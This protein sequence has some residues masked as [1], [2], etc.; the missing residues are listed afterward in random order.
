MIVQSLRSSPAANPSSITESRPRAAF[1]LI[2]D[3]EKSILTLIARS[4]RQFM[5]M[6]E[7]CGDAASALAAIKHR[8]PDFIF[9]DVSLE[10]FDA[11]EVIRGL[12]E[13]QF[14]GNIQL[15]SGRDLPLLEDIKRVGE[16]YSLKML[17]VLQKPFRIDAIMEILRH[18]G[19]GRSSGPGAKVSLFS[20][21]CAG[22]LELNY[23]PIVDL[24]TMHLA[25]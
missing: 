3:D 5:V 17:P 7:E 24:R 6:T 16:R 23:Q 1:C 25:G 4:L 9:L 13:I 14:S 11:V 12:G 19:L 15:M 2:V 22:W 20:A 8:T 10:R 18:A 21:L